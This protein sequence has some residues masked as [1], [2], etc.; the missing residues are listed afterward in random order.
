MRQFGAILLVCAMQLFAVAGDRPDPEQVRRLAELLREERERGGISKYEHDQKHPPS[1]ERSDG[2]IGC[3]E[4]IGIGLLSV[5]WIL[6]KAGA[7]TG[8]GSNS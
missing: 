4:W 7:R 3:W 2:G 8:T 6:G 1:S 5:V